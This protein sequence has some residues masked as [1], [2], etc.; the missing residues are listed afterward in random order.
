M[1]L[2][3]AVM[4]AGGSALEVLR[5]EHRKPLLR[6]GDAFGAADVEHVPVR[7]ER[8]AAGVSGTG[9]VVTRRRSRITATATATAPALNDAASHGMLVVGSRSV[10]EHHGQGC[11]AAQPGEQVTSDAAV[12]G[13]GGRRR[14]GRPVAGHGV[15][16][17][18]GVDGDHEVRAH[19]VVTGEPTG[20]HRIQQGV[21]TLDTAPCHRAVVGGMSR[22]GERVEQGA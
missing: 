21:E 10:G 5:Q 19:A 3:V 6:G 17:D 7:G 8:T 1:D 15:R 20:Q 16:E 12:A 4:A 18:G 2:Q 11:V 22:L 13:Q 14:G 9:R